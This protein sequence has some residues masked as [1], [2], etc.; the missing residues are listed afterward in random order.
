MAAKIAAVKAF[1]RVNRIDR[2]VL[3]RGGWLRVVT[4]GK[5]HLDLMEALRL[6]GI[7]EAEAAEIGL[8]VYKI[9]LSWP[10]EPDGALAFARGA[11]EILVVEEKAP[12]VE[13]QLKDLLYHLPDGERPHALVGKTDEAGA[14]LLPA[15]GELR[16]WIVAKAL[17]E[18]LRRRFPDHPFVGHATDRLASLLPAETIAK[19]PAIRTPYFCSGCPHNT[20][21]KVPEGS[22][23]LAGIGCHFMASWMDRDTVGLAQMGGEGVSWVGQAP[24]PPARTSFKISAK[25]PISI[26]AVWRSDRPSP[27]TSTSPTKSCSTTRS[28]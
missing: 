15:T 2:T 19:P 4:T 5:A 17:V 7:G 13:G 1:A 24:F 9:G 23:A 27:P 12:L 18:R 8:S 6:L 28:P 25:A 16:P 11:E 22:K 14:P 21:T 26:P 20:S 3:G 10:L